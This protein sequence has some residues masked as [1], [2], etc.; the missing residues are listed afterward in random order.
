MRANRLLWLLWIVVATIYAL[1]G[2]VMVA[3]GQDV[4]ANTVPM[5]MALALAKLYE[6]DGDDR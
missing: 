3:A 1:R 4:S 2:L 5:L 6:M